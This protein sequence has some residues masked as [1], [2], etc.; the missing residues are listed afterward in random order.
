MFILYPILNSYY[1]GF[2][3]SPPSPNTHGVHLSV[4]TQSCQSNSFDQFL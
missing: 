1:V 4:V 3:E 2:R